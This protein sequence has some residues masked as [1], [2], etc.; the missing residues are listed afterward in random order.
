MS[1][2]MTPKQV[3]RMRE[4]LLG[5]FSYF[6]QVFTEPSFFDDTFHTELCRFMQHSKKDKLVV[7]PRTFQIGRAHV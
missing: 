5:D 4:L 1:T 3:N 2:S 7:L 6:A